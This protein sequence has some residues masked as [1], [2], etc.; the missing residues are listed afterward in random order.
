MSNKF[1]NF[2]GQVFNSPYNMKDYAHASRLYVN[3]FYRLTPKVGFLYYVVF[4]INRNNNALI[5]NFIQQNGSEVGLLVKSADLPKFKM[6]T[7]GLNQYNKKTYV[8]SKI[9]YTPI[10]ISFHDDNNNTTSGLWNAYYHYYFADGK[11]TNGIGKPAGYRDNKY[12][13]A[14]GVLDTTGYGLNNNQTGAFFDSIEIYQ[15]NRKQFTCFILINPIISDWGH[16]KVDQSQTSLL[17]NKMTIN[18]ETVL[19]GTG[20]VRADNPAGFAKFHYDNS[21]SPLSIFGGG[22]NSLFGPGGI[23]PGMSQIFGS[24]LSSPLGIF[25]AARAGSNLI[26]NAKN[27]SGASIRAEGYSILGG[28]LGNIQSSGSVSEGVSKSLGGLGAVFGGSGNS[29]VNG[30][31]SASP[32]ILN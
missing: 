7:E 32:R 13:P 25:Q 3:D 21:P 17:E 31:T 19:Y 22:N 16:D 14:S 29:S 28:V 24:D 30:V 2:I 9:D 27:V 20:Q 10:N 5:Q 23:I 6:T 15:M 4:N 8:Q 26:R 18:Y 12:Q 11:N 1:A